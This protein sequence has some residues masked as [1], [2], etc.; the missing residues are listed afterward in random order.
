MIYPTL[1]MDFEAKSYTETKE[2]PSDRTKMEGGYVQTRRK[3]TRRP[4]KTFTFSYTELPDADKILLENFFESV[5]GGCDIFQFTSPQG[6]AFD[7]RFSKAID[8]KFMGVGVS[9]LFI[10]SA[11]VSLEEV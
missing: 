6:T 5:G 4:R 11:Q 8:F 7:V 2:D 10:W 3:F 1:S 9:R